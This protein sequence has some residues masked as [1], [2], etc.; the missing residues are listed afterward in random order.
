MKT[1]IT[2]NA[3]QKCDARDCKN[4]ASAYF[5]V[6]GRLGRCYLCAECMQKLANDVLSTVTPKSPK[7]TI[8]R[9]ADSREREKN[10]NA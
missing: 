1:L 8:K 5:A 3:K 4:T 9:I 6:K 2:S 10:V 7:N